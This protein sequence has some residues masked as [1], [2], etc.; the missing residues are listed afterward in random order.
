MVLKIT[1]PTL[2]RSDQR[3]ALS[4]QSAFKKVDLAL[5]RLIGGPEYTV[6]FESKLPGVFSHEMGQERIDAGPNSRIVRHMMRRG[7]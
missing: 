1:H 7:V 2:D 5:D 6:V 4:E 3:R